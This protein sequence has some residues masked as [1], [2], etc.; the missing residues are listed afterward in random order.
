MIVSIAPVH[1][2]LMPQPTRLDI[3]AT[4]LALLIPISSEEEAQVCCSSQLP[5]MTGTASSL[6][7]VNNIFCG[8]ISDWVNFHIYDTDAIILGWWIAAALGLLIAHNIAIPDSISRETKEEKP[9][10]L[11]A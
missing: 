11:E 7:S 6:T 5:S 10:M 4:S 3:E 8:S 1:F 2:S 9:F